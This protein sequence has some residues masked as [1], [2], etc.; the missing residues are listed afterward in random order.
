MEQRPSWTS[1]YSFILATIGSAVGLG[2]IWRFPYIMG[3]YGGAVFLFVYLL[4]IVT[5]CFIPMISELAFGKI[6]KKE[7]IT[8]YESVNPKLK[9]FG[10]LNPVT[11]ILISSFY[12]IVGGW[13]I[14]YILISIKNSSIADYSSYFSDFIQMPYLNCFLTLLFLF[15]CLF[16]T[17]RGVKK[18]LNLQ[19]TC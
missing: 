6:V 7:C 3:Q 5:I 10:F 2:N 1:K 8:A 15:M 4:L 9:L 14:N 16:F 18:V 13:I 11:G 17:A 12:F 19:I